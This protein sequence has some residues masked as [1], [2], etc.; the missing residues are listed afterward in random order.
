MLVAIDMMDLVDH[1]VSGDA[2]AAYPEEVMQSGWNPDVARLMQASR[3]DHDA[4]PCAPTDGRARSAT[5]PKA[6]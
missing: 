4:G 5:Q 2:W 1:G 3:T 6:A